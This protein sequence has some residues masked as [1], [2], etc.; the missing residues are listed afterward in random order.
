ML[1]YGT[2][3]KIILLFYNVNVIAKGKL[4]EAKHIH[5]IYEKFIDKCPDLDESE[6]VDPYQL[7]SR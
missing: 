4:E 3:R 2:I 1:P 6:P 7:F 5:E